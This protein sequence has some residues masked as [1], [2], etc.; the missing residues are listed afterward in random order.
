MIRIYIGPSIPGLKRYTVF[1]DALPKPIAELA[2]MNDNV[3]GLII[4]IEKL[5]E[6]RRD[7]RKRG[8]VLNVYFHKLSEGVKNHG[9]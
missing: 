1:S 5:Q 6:S 9:V 4:P 2:A 8:H 7:T 3:A